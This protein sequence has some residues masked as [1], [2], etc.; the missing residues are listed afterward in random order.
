MAQACPGWA[1][2]AGPRMLSEYITRDAVVY[3]RAV[4]DS[5]LACDE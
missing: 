3:A 5:V 2:G 1:E 4:M